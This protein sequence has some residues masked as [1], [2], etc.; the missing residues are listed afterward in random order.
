[1]FLS[2]QKNTGTYWIFYKNELTKKYNRKNTGLA[3]EELA[4]GELKTFTPPIKTL[5]VSKAKNLMMVDDSD[6]A[7]LKECYQKIYDY[8]CTNNKKNKY[9]VNFIYD[10]LKKCFG[11]SIN[12]NKLTALQIEEF[13]RFLL[14]NKYGESTINHHLRNMKAYLNK[15]KFWELVK[16]D[17]ADKIHYYKGCEKERLNFTD[18]EI[19]TIFESIT[20]PLFYNFCKFALL[21]GM[22][23]AEITHL[24]WT[25]I[26][27]INRR[28]KVINKANHKTKS[29]KNRYIPITDNLYNLLD[30]MY[31]KD[32]FK[33]Y[34]FTCK[35]GTK[36]N[37][38]YATT[39]FTRTKKQLNLNSDLCFHS[40]RHSFAVNYLKATNNIYALKKLLG[41][42]KIQ[43][44]E[45]YL[46]YSDTD[47]L[48]DGMNQMKV[49]I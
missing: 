26:D 31:K 48:L 24:Q 22:R 47:E 33:N 17:I 27:F 3:D 21:T 36:L 6:A 32:N 37:D 45:I 42:S 30:G 18:L 13:K 15:L 49:A 2:F 23:K 14:K 39:Q 25:D 9:D 5:S 11:E 41:H 20:I 29:R 4:K 1:M 19:K 28:I 7:F 12:L 38:D 35:S 8:Y 40:F 34:V 43:T 16:T 44:T 10:N 46:H